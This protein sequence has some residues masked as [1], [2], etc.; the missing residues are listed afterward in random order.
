VGLDDL[1]EDLHREW[2]GQC[3]KKAG[4]QIVQ[5]AIPKQLVV[6][7]EMSDTAEQQLLPEQQS[8][9]HIISAAVPI[10]PITNEKGP[11]SLDY[12]SKVPIHEGGNAFTSNR[13]NDSTVVT[14]PVSK[15]SGSSSSHLSTKKNNGGSVKQSVG[16]MKRIARMSDVDR[17]AILKVLK[18]QKRKIKVGKVNSNDVSNSTSGSTK[19]SSSSGGKDWENW[20]LL[21]GK[22]TEV[23]DDVRDIGKV[24]GVRYN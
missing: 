13:V 19:N 4:S 16:F 8:S 5:D 20:V 10:Q 14:K 23:A 3:S 7:K 24:V 2:S 9:P 17:L 21:H 11:W 12:L 22:P 1:V 6:T 15:K 18:K